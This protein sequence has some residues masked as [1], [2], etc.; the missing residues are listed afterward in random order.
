MIN[1]YQNAQYYGEIELGTPGQKFEVIYDTGS[2]DLWVASNS[3]GSSCGSHAKYVS[4]KSST[5][6]ANGTNFHIMYGSGPVS[7][8][9]SQDNLNLGGLVVKDQ[10]FAEV[11]DAKGLG[12]AYKVGKFDGIL[13]L[14][15]PILSVNKVPTVFENLVEQKTVSAGQFAFYLGT[16]S[17]ADGELVFGGYDTNHFT[18]EISWVNLKAPTYWEIQLDALNVDGTNYVASGGASAIV[19]SGTSMLTAPKDVVKQLA[20]KIGAKKFIGGEYVTACS[21]IDSFPDFE[22]MIDGKTYTLT[23]KEYMVRS[24]NANDKCMQ[25]LSTGIKQ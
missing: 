18:G 20:E 8:F 21:K 3:C 2:S 24:R 4:S 6:V 16:S 5:Y 10:I 25:A 22:F 1:D 19:D 11:T 14:A 15:F 17:G 7:G 12:A 23:P 9:E 13:G